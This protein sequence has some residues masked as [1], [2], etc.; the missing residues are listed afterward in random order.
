LSSTALN[1]FGKRQKRL[2]TI[3]LHCFDEEAIEDNRSPQC[4]GIV[5]R[6]I[7]LNSSAESSMGH[8]NRGTTHGSPSPRI[9]IA[10]TDDEASGSGSSVG[11][12]VLLGALRRWWWRILP[13]SLLAAVLGGVAGWILTVPKYSAAAYL[14]IDSDNRTLIFKTA[15]EGGSASNF[16]LYRSTQQQKMKIPFVLN[17]A[18]RKE[19]ISS[20]PELAE[21]PS[22]ME[23]LQ[24]SIKV[25]FPDNGE[26]MRASVETQSGD[27]CVKIINAV[28]KAYMDEVVLNERND[29]LKRVDN[30]ERVYSEAEQKVRTKRSELRAL[31]TALG[32]SDTDSLTVAQQNALQQFGVM[33]NKLSEVQFQLM[34]AEGELEIARKWEEQTL[35]EMREFAAR[36][37][38]T[39]V[40][41]PLADF[42]KP[43]EITR[44]ED[45]IARSRSRLASLQRD[46]G[47]K[48][49]SYRRLAEEVAVSEQILKQNL[50]QA[51][52]AYQK[53]V[54]LD[55]QR[56]EG[57]A[58]GMNPELAGKLQSKYD[59][60]SLIARI[61]TLKKQENLLLKEVDK[62]NEETRELGRSSIDVELMRAEIDSLEEVLQRVSQEVE[63][64]N[65][66]LQ[67]DSRIRLLSAAESATPPDP[68]KRY[69][70]AGALG[71]FGLFLPFGLVVLWDLTRRKVDDVDSVSKALSIDSIGTIPKATWDFTRN[72]TS[73]RNQMKHFRLLESVS[74]V[75]TM[76]LHRAEHNNMK[77]F[78]IT[79]AVSGEGKSS[80]AC[81]LS[82]SLSQFGKK[83]ALIDFD[84]R[85]PT[86]HR[87]FD[88]PQTPGVAE[89]LA[90][91]C[92]L[93]DCMQHVGSHSLDI[94]VAGQ[95][96]VSLQ[97]K[98][99]DGTVADLF[100]QLR[101]EYDI[102]I[103]D[104]CPILPVV[105]SRL[106]SKYI[107]GVVFT[108]LRD[109][110]R[111]PLATRAVEILKSFGVN[112]LGALVIGGGQE[113]YGYHGYNYY[114]KQPTLL[115][116][117]PESGA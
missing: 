108:L 95:V 85:R 110:S 19:G 44:M 97:R 53:Q 90:G 81:L 86:V 71:V 67:T 99:T 43:P 3:V 29:R 22:P 31:A 1:I 5:Q 105:D 21:A 94:F 74:S 72:P 102:V 36:N 113:Q 12:G 8:G 18:L 101:H 76:L 52:Q 103:V 6:K 104:S 80:V 28:V 4:F 83:V 16:Q 13:L 60:V 57:T 100:E 49:P 92:S 7:M 84:L 78:M 77:V 61:E 11:I 59:I 41:T 73:A 40:E 30:L 15:D 112:L 109:H 87:F 26:I 115:P 93:A 20:L 33:Q 114:A 42:V 10:R 96:E 107:D 38:A 14:Q 89:V 63:R 69:M 62:L 75:A 9:V 56:L 82:R 91:E 17:A 70:R 106:I 116:A 88:I 32:T 65:I 54:E 45:E 111:F 47:I 68:K 37:A 50:E 39:E 64:T 66:E 23:W 46:L 24:K 27:S 55:R 2:G 51:Q 98:I 48:H 58:P 25:E 79:S 34:Q 35:A 117:A